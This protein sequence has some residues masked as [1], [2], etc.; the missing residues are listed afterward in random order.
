MRN[1]LVEL[2]ITSVLIYKGDCVTQSPLQA[3][4]IV[5]RFRQAQTGNNLKG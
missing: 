4:S 3:R 2:R 5:T 1:E